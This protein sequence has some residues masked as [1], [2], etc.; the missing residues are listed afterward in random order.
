MQGYKQEHKLE[1]KEE[2]A[3]IKANLSHFVKYFNFKQLPNFMTIFRILIIPVIVIT[4]YFDDIKFAHRIAAILFFLAGLTDFLDGFLA[5]RY[6]LQSNLGRI[7]DPIADKLL[8]GSILLMVVKFNKANE[9]PCMLILAREILISGLREFLAEVRV[10]VPVSQLAKIKTTVQMFALFI[11]L[12]SDNGSLLNL[13][14][15]LSLWLAAIL[16]LITGYSYL[17]ASKDYI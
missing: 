9:I 13:I 11:L 8:V 4:F 5:R 17:K 7:L 12:L 14:G 1:L 6:N 10:S 2:S 16:T 15:H 3:G